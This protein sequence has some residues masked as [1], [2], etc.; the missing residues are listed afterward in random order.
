MSGKVIFRAKASSSGERV[1]G[2][3][4]ST[5]G[6]QFSGVTF[7]PLKTFFFPDVPQ[8]ITGCSRVSQGHQPRYGHDAAER[9]GEAC[10]SCYDFRYILT[11]YPHW[12]HIN[13]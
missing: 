12:R 6:E 8:D 4:A 3:V 11:M 7:S 1:G 10:I 13:V 9:T 5:F 2:V